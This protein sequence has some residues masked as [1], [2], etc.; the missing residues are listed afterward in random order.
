M[1][2]GILAYLLS[3]AFDIL[4]YFDGIREKIVNSASA[5]TKI[6]L[7]IIYFAIPQ[8]GSTHFYAASFLSET[9]SKSVMSFW[10]VVHTLLYIC[11][12]WI[13]T[14]FVFSKKE[15]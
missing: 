14:V 15:F 8:W 1:V 7:E 4:F 9:F 3:T 12:I 6:I 2:F 10:P 5:L 13:M 11:L